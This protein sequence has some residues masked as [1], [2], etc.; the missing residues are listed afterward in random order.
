MKTVIFCTILL[1]SGL[2]FAGKL[3]DLPEV[4]QPVDIHVYGGRLFIGENFTI[5]V[6]SLK[7]FKQLKQFGKRGDGPGEFRFNARL[8]VFPD[9]LA[10]NCRGRLIYFNHD[11]GL[12]KTIKTKPEIHNLLPVGT[13]FAASVYEGGKAQKIKLYNKDIKYVTTVYEGSLG[14]ATY[15]QSD[16][17]KIDLLL[18]K[19]F[20]DERVY[21]N[22]IYVGDTGKGFYFAVFNG[23]G[24]KLYDAN[25]KYEPLQIPEA[26]K[27]EQ[28]RLQQEKPGW[29]RVKD[30]VNL[31]FPKYFPAYRMM[32]ISD[33]KIYF[34]THEGSSGKDKVFV[35][36]LKGKILGQTFA[37]S[38]VWTFCISKG[39]LY[40][41]VENEEE[42]MWELYSIN[43][44]QFKRR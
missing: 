21:Q 42:E 32:Q 30:K 24:K 35:T 4:M 8:D 34:V 11:G 23:A 6:Y 13:N 15:W 2:S 3:A 43:A 41:L 38:N 16:A 7:D 18:V 9:K 39:K 17:K 28:I 40:W 27:K 29:D 25:N 26:Y 5:H 12:L 19:D 20:M 10:V 22:K 33:D 44:N 14:Q 1:L 31:R 36:D 37:P